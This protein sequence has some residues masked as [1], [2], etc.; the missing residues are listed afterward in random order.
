MKTTLTRF[1]ITTSL[2]CIAQPLALFAQDAEQPYDIATVTCS[3]VMILSG[4]DRDTTLAFI[5]G[6]IVGTSG[7]SAFIAS[8]LTDAT[9]D[10]LETCIANPTDL[11]VA[12]MREAIEN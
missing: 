12:T 3:D 1:A 6:F 2:F 9:D 11:A 5:H 10:F 7:E 8:K 4:M